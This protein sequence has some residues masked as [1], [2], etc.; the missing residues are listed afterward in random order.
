MIRETS[1][2]PGPIYETIIGRHVSERCGFLSASEITT[3]LEGCGLVLVS[4]QVRGKGGDPVT[5][6]AAYLYKQA[7][8]ERLGQGA[9]TMT[10]VNFRLM[11][12]R[13]RDCRRT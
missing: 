7:I 11:G 4:G 10:R 6:D 3:I 2:E 8:R 13:C 1:T 5:E 12:C 9:Y